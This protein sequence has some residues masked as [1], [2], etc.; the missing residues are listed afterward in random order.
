[1]SAPKMRKAANAGELAA[2][3]NTNISC[4]HTL[5]HGLVNSNLTVC[6][7]ASINGYQQQ[8]GINMQDLP[9]HAIQAIM[10][11]QF[12]AFA[13]FGPDPCSIKAAAAHEAGHAVVAEALGDEVCSV[14]VFKTGPLWLGRNNRASARSDERYTV[15]EYP[16]NALETAMMYA[17]GFAGEV[18]AG[19]SHPSSSL[20]ERMQSNWLCDE[21]DRVLNLPDGSSSMAVAIGMFA[22]LNTNRVAFDVVR[23]HLVREHQLR[24][25]DARRILQKVEPFE[26]SEV[27][28]TLCGRAQA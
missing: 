12:D 8:G 4:D 17:A 18:V 20:D 5:P 10:Q 13:K 3:Q 2:F 14:K 23:G 22:I 21:L 15:S 11:T 24:N 9:P 27:F 16:Q 6:H 26:T 25:G 1:M 7:S 28:S 19:L